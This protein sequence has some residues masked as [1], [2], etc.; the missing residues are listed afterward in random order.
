MSATTSEN[1]NENSLI[2][3][4]HEDLNPTT[5]D[6]AP[7]LEYDEHDLQ[8]IADRGKRKINKKKFIH[9]FE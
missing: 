4:G 1:T 9:K 5:I 7:Q 2:K 8:L 6:Y 3:V